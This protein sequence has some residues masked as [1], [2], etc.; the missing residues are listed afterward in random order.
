VGQACVTEEQQLGITWIM[1]AKEGSLSKGVGVEGGME[2]IGN[3]SCIA[4]MTQNV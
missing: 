2:D 4:A 1:E 3:S